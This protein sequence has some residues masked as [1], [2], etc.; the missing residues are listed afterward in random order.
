[1]LKESQSESCDSRARNVGDG[2]R[3]SQRSGTKISMCAFSATQL[4]RL[5]QE[6]WAEQ[7][8]PPFGI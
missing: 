3:S 8:Q 2:S 6:D 7:E 4:A 1:M 5:L